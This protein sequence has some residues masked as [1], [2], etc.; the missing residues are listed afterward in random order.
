[1]HRGGG[2]SR[3]P[4]ARRVR[5]MYTPRLRFLPF[6]GGRRWGDRGTSG[7]VRS[8][9]LPYSKYRK[10]NSNHDHNILENGKSHY[11][12]ECGKSH[13]LT[14]IFQKN[15]EGRQP[16]WRPSAS[17]GALPPKPPAGGGLRP[18]PGREPAR[19]LTDG[20]PHGS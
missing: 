15:F 11:G 3:T 14:F 12:L 18:P 17:W 20:N 6:G 7:P 5:Y 8:E 9:G 13:H 16:W 4:P 10:T 19:E 1:M 2:G